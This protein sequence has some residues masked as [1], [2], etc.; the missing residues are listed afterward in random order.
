M[1]DRL[2]SRRDFVFVLYELQGLR[3]EEI[4]QALEI[5]LKTVWTRLYHARRELTAILKQEVTSELRTS[6]LARGLP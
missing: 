4:A 5:P 1:Q 3:G 6:G 2:I